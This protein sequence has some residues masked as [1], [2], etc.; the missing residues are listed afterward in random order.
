M[1]RRQATQRALLLHQGVPGRVLGSV[2]CGGCRRG[3]RRASSPRRVPGHRQPVREVIRLPVADRQ[4][5]RHRHR[6]MGDLPPR[7][8]DAYQAQRHPRVGDR[9]RRDRA[10]AL[11]A[12]E[13]GAGSA[14]ARRWGGR[15]A[16]RIEGSWLG[17]A[18]RNEVRAAFGGDRQDQRPVCWR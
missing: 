7:V 15:R 2:G 4:L 5:R 16:E 10:E 1:A 12:Q 18:A 9:H 14:A 13:A 11:P 8:P 17:L 3:C 6:E